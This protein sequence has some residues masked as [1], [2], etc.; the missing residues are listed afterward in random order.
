M[1]LWVK[2]PNFDHTR[3]VTLRTWANTVMRNR[4]R[5]ILRDQTQLGR[6]NGLSEV[7]FDDRIAYHAENY[8]EIEMMEG[9][10]IMAGVYNDQNGETRVNFQEIGALQGGV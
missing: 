5:N 6:H 8:S 3:G 1:H 10:L 7:S 9:L 4:L 2:L